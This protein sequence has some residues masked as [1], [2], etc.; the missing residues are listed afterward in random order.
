[1]GGVATSMVIGA[2]AGAACTVPADIG[3]RA[4]ARVVFTSGFAHRFTGG[5]KEFAIEAA[6]LRGVIKAME[7]RFPGLGDILEEET[8]VV[9]DGEM[10]EV[11]YSQPLAPG[12][13]VFFLPRI[14]GG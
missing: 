6:T 2:A 13:E 5:V 11:V 1:M 3:A 10:H 14:E 9:L 7:A 4:P 12:C 8:S